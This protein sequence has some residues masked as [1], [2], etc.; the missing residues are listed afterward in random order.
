MHKR[1][2]RPAQLHER[3]VLVFGAGTARE[4]VWR[5]LSLAESVSESEGGSRGH[6]VSR[7]QARSLRRCHPALLCR[8][9]RERAIV[10]VR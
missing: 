3:E 6:S 10:H 8:G 1:R 2:K 4:A 5:R 9:Y 7:S